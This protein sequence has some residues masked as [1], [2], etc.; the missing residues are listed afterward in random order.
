[1]DSMCH[2]LPVGGGPL[3]RLALRR[4]DFSPTLPRTLNSYPVFPEASSWQPNIVLI[5]FCMSWLTYSFLQTIAS[6]IYRISV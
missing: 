1:M 3:I 5:P 6:T 4:P 2:A